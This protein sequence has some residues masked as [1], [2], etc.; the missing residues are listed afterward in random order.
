VSAS[1]DRL[2]AGHSF[3]GSDGS[4]LAIGTLY[5]SMESSMVKVYRVKKQLKLAFAGSTKAK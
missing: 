5:L 4:P 1:R 2:T 3:P